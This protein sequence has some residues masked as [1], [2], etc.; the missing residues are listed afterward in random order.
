M[1][2][3]LNGTDVGLG[4]IAQLLSR[5]V[6]V[7]HLL[8]VVVLLEALERVVDH[9][10]PAVGSVVPEVLDVHLLEISNRQRFREVVANRVEN[11]KKKTQK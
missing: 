1:E 6:R 4:L 7:A 8:R 10:G 9:F 5:D 2:I 3:P 11:C